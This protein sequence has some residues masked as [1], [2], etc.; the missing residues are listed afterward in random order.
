MVE[1]YIQQQP[2]YPF[3]KSIDDGHITSEGILLTRSFPSPL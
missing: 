1:R 3:L 2:S